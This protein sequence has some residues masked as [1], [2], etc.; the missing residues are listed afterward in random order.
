MTVEGWTEHSKYQHVF[1]I[2]R[3]DQF[4]LDVDVEQGI[5]VTKVVTSV[6]EAAAEVERLNAL[7]EKAGG[8]S[9]YFW[10]VTRLV[11]SAEAAPEG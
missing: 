11:P 6:E 9:R 5:T 3:V 10:Q 7:R 2:V 4:T 1:A 8:R